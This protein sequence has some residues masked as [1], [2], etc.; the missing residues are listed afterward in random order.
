M[1]F[2]VL[3]PTRNR[4]ELL[5]FAVASVIKQDYENW[6][7]I[8]SDNFSEE[9][10]AGYVETLK[11]PRIKYFRTPSFVPVTEN[12]NYALDRS[13]GDYVIMLGDDDCLMQGYFS[14]LFET[15][16]KHDCPDFIYTGALQYVYPGAV[17]RRQQ[18]C[19]YHYTFDL[20]RLLRTLLAFK[21]AGH[22]ISKPISE[23]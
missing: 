23:F 14:N 4:I 22:G 10:I 3:L 19:L 18:G 21:R 13:S 1:K 12:W 6:E 20:F 5:K 7:I 16:Q 2:S 11:D 15:I 17:P 9:D 8:I